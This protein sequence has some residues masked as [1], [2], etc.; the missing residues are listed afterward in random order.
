MSEREDSD[1]GAEAV[2]HGTVAPDALH[3]AT[4]GCEESYPDPS[5]SSAATAST[6]ADPS[7][8]LND[9]L[10]MKILRPSDALI[11]KPPATTNY[12]YYG[13]PLSIWQLKGALLRICRSYDLDGV[14][15]PRMIPE[16]TFMLENKLGF[17]YP[18]RTAFVK[19]GKED[20]DLP[21]KL[22]PTAPG[23]SFLFL[24]GTCGKPFQDQRPT[25]EQVRILTDEWFGNPA[26]WMEDAKSKEDWLGYSWAC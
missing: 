19:A 12:C 7:T 6:P 15:I 25:Q 23:I 5:M 20:K 18:L 13:W 21:L 2:L 1:D 22:Y 4:T 26:Q 17:R 9:S 8:E 14:P 11:P 10:Y 3:D 16:M 24:V